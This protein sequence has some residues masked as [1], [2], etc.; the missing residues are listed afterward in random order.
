[1]IHT[2]FEVR[3]VFSVKSFPVSYLSLKVSVF[4][5]MSDHTLYYTILNYQ[6]KS[7]LKVLTRCT[8]NSQCPCHMLYF[9][10]NST[11]LEK[12]AFPFYFLLLLL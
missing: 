1:M 5:Q 8:Y 6:A 11:L 3:L 9:S 12:E 2:L 10:A 4:S 7:Q